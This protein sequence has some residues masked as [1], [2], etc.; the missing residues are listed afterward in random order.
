MPW[1]RRV[2]VDAR[3]HTVSSAA[4]EELSVHRRASAASLPILIAVEAGR[5][6]EAVWVCLDMIKSR[7][8][9][10]TPVF[11]ARSSVDTLPQAR[12]LSHF[13][14]RRCPARVEHCLNDTDVGRPEIHGRKPSST[15]SWPGRHWCE[16]NGCEQKPSWL[17]L[18]TFPSFA[19]KDWRKAWKTLDRGLAPIV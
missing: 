13:V 4:R 7:T 15:R 1:R 6:P 16:P 12:Y 8:G 11:P 9:T 3:C 19:L 10:Q 18:G 2:E 14:Q 5:T 17:V